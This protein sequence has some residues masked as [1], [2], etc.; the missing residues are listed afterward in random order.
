MLYLAITFENKTYDKR[1]SLLPIVKN[2]TWTFYFTP[3]SEK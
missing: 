2:Q 1:N 3:F